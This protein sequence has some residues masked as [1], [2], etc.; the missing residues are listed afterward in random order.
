[1]RGLA[2][3]IGVPFPFRYELHLKNNKSF[4]EW[5]LIDLLTKFDENLKLHSRDITGRINFC[6]DFLQHMSA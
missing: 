5:Q 1:M 3:E 4:Y 6:G 2:F